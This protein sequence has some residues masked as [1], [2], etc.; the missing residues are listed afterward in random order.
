MDHGIP[1]WGGQSPQGLRKLSLW[2]MKQG[3]EL[4]WSRIRHPQTQ[5]KVERFHRELQRALQ[6]RPPRGQELQTWLDQFRWEHN[7]L[8]PH[9][10]LDMETPG[11]R[12]RPSERR[13]NPPAWDYPSGSR[14]LKIDSDGKI[15]L[16]QQHW[17]ISRALC[18]ERVRL[19]TVEQRVLVYY[20]RTVVRERELVS[21]RSTVVDRWLTQENPTTVKDVPRHFVS[22]V[23][24]LDTS[25]EKW[26]F[27]QQLRLLP[28]VAAVP[29]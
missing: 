27:N 17:L 10:A 13:S 2:L 24:G 28:D 6:R 7:H 20:C 4:H 22:D 12:W 16:Q 1:W 18:G 15:K 9:E 3:I 21:Q 5:D 19:V 23:V 8:R 26:G 14:V 25:G 29:Q 11:S